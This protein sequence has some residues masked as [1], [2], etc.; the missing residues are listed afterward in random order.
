MCIAEQLRL[1]YRVTASKLE[2]LLDDYPRY[3]QGRSGKWFELTA[4][5][6]GKDVGFVRYKKR[7]GG[8]SV[9]EV[10]VD[11]T[12]RRRGYATEMYDH[13][14]EKYGKLFKS[15]DQTDE[16]KAFRKARG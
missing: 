11:P 4:K 10:F 16:G 1:K 13:I 3:A 14:E 8:F 7:S 9:I 15:K 2:F 5:L 12:Y 6:N